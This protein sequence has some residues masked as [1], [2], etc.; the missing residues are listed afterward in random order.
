VTAEAFFSLMRLLRFVG[1]PLPSR[2]LAGERDRD[3]SYVFGFRRIRES[4][5]ALWE[6]FFRGES[7]KALEG[8][9]MTLLEHAGARARAAE[10]ED[11]LLNIR[12]FWIEE[13]SVLA[14][15]IRAMGYDEYPCRRRSATRSSFVTVRDSSGAARRKVEAWEGRAGRL[16]A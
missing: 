10:V 7:T 16:T 15:C 4:T 14:A 13:A 11:D 12:R 8:L 6:S 5:I 1:H 3:Y 2:D 9:T